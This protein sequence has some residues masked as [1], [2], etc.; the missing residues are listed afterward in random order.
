MSTSKKTPAADRHHGGPG[1]SHQDASKPETED[2]HGP[3]PG[4]PTN[5]SK[6]H[7]S[8]GGGEPDQHHAHDAPGKGAARSH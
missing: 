3:N 6:S 7:V 8:G 5:D 1:S 4:S 2:R